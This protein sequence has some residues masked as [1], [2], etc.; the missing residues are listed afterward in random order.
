MPLPDVS[1]SRAGSRFCH[2]DDY[3]SGALVVMAAAAGALD[4]GVV[5]ESAGVADGACV[6]F[7]LFLPSVYWSSLVPLPDVELGD[8]CNVT[9]RPS[10]P[11]S[12]T[13]TL[14]PGSLHTYS[15][16]R[17]RRRRR[18]RRSLDR[19]T[20]LSLFSA[21]LPFCHSADVRIFLAD[22]GS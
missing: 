19:P 8:R 14:F 2:C 15:H 12:C 5:V 16:V 20:L 18:R 9:Q 7:F 3:G 17:W 1:C 11:S 4:V 22:P 21:P 13:R 6:I 10:P